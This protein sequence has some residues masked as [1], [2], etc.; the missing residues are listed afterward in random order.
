MAL[1]FGMALAA[2][3]VSA[4][5]ITISSSVGGA[6]TGTM[7]DNL[8]W[9]PLGT[10]GGTSP[11]TGIIVS[12]TPDGQAVQG[13]I[14]S[15]YA[16]PYLSG[17][18]GAGFGS[19]NQPDGVDA[20]TYATTGLGTVTITMSTPEKYFGLLWGSVDRY[21]TLSFY[22]GATLVG[23]VTGAQVLASPNGDQGVNGTV[24]V[25]LGFD[26]AF[27]K[28]VASSTQYAFEFDNVAFNP[29]SPVPEPTSLLLLGTGLLG[30]G[31]AWRRRRR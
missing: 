1:L 12:F 9:L 26:T 4:D 25:N 23:S 17:G 6:P 3:P 16:A 31:R 28:V 22:N 11:S 14:G 19:P 5:P 29:T 30:A 15:R 13:S 18:N 7:M 24:Y 27:D 21:N 10:A 8:N 20:T 2:A